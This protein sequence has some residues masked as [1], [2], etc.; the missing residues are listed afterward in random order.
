MMS[1]VWFPKKVHACACSELKKNLD[2]LGRNVLAWVDKKETLTLVHNA[3]PRKIRHVV[4]DWVSIQ[5]K[6]AVQLNHFIQV[7]VSAQQNV[8]MS[9]L[10]MME[11]P[12]IVAD[13]YSFIQFVK[14]NQKKHLSED[15]YR[16][17]SLK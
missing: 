1:Y 3:T 12:H 9:D 11:K 17:F 7:W 4:W 6:Y 10:M 16:E 15:Q 13:W 2:I 14:N 8:S 5:I